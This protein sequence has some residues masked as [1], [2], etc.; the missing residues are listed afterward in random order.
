VP[1]TVVSWTLLAKIAA[2]ARYSTLS[3]PLPDSRFAHRLQGVL[4]TT[5]ATPAAIG[6]A[7][8]WNTS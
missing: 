7:S 2:P 8:P 5:L 4:H 1:V 3:C 6:P